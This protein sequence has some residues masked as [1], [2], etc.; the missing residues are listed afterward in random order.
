M[1]VPSASFA[2]L[3]ESGANDAALYLKKSW[4]ASTCSMITGWTLDDL[5]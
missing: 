3:T 4:R 2:S 1:A 5:I